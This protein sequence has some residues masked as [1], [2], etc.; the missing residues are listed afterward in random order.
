MS[1]SDTKDET[2]DQAPSPEDDRKPDAPTDLTKRSWFYVLR[3]TMHEFTDD[4]CTDLAAALTYY[5]VLAIFPA[6]LA[7]ASILGVVGQADKAVKTVMDIIKPLVTSPATQQRIQDILT[8]MA[9]SKSAGLTLVIGLLAALWSASGYVGAFGRAM[10][11]IYE[12]EEG[13]P[14]W[15][16]RPVM[17]LLTLVAVVLAAI[18][19]VMLIVSGPVAESLGNVIGLGSTAVTV[20]SIAKWPE[21][22]LALRRCRGRDRRVGPG[23]GRL[24]LLRRELLQLQQD[25]RRPRGGRR[26]AA[27]AVDHQPGPALRR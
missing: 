1:R 21:V 9:S 23:H 14:F 3:K 2:R 17:L 16:L 10:N 11:R 27:V 18:A 20:W 13:R 19:L 26:R 5:A 6:A 15:K 25:L 8:Q 4:Q 7:L 12:I 22:P 24:R